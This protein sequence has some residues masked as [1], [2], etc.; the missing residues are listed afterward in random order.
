MSTINVKHYGATGD[1]TTDDVEALQTAIASAVMG[2]RIIFPAG[3]YFV[4]DTLALTQSDVVYDL[5][6]AKIIGNT[7]KPTGGGTIINLF[8]NHCV[9]MG[10]T[11][12]PRFK[13]GNPLQAGWDN[14]FNIV[15]NYNTLLHV[16]VNATDGWR[17]IDIQTIGD[18]IHHNKFIN[19][20]ILG[21][22]TG[23]SLICATGGLVTDTVFQNCLIEFANMGI[24]IYSDD[25][26][27]A[28]KN[29]EFSNVNILNC[30][31]VL[32][33]KGIDTLA[34]DT[35][36]IAH[37]DNVLH[38][39]IDVK[40]ISISNLEIDGEVWIQTLIRKLKWA[41]RFKKLKILFS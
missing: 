2:D 22:D 33:L 17:G 11:I 35:I 14:G 34:L 32:S 3:T 15:G 30:H 26:V 5:G 13:S 36:F 10:G 23:I 27:L 6:T 18:H 41:L 16:T 38:R 40:N 28:N 31:E 12:V 29:I 4:S 24:L 7:D 25:H 19:C 8:G 1:G 9:V 21:G 37:S 39:A 20:H